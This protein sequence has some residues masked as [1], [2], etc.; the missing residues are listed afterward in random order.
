MCAQ[1]NEWRSFCSLA[2]V[3]RMILFLGNNKNLPTEAIRY[4][5]IENKELSIP[6]Y[7]NTK[8]M[9]ENIYRLMYSRFVRMV[10]V[11][12][13]CCTVKWIR[14]CTHNT[15]AYIWLGNSL[16][17]QRASDFSLS[18]EKT[19]H[20]TYE[21]VKMTTVYLN[22]GSTVF[23]QKTAISHILKPERRKGGRRYCNN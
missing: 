6:H 18:F 19:V 8:F 14:Q 16:K 17:M 5:H 21:I 15:H 23:A 20:S 12:V 13:Y 1:T 2:S 4:D 3:R 11:C 7:L 10:W 22:D 9:L